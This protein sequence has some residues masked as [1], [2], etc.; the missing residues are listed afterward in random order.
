MHPT[1]VRGPFHRDS[2]IYEEKIDG[3]RMLAYNAGKNVRVL[4][5]NHVDHSKRF[6]EPYP[7]APS[8]STV[9][10][11]SSTSSSARASRNGA[12]LDD[13]VGCHRMSGRQRPCPASR[14]IP[15]R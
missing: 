7:V 4:N 8:H 13:L 9:K 12:G 11:R 1:L 3:Y 5:R 2:W 14:V 6:P 10:S 15:G